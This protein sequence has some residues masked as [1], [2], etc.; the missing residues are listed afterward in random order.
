MKN[1]SC[2]CNS[3][4]LVRHISFCS[5]CEIS[6]CLVWWR[7]V[8]F[9]TYFK[10]CVCRIRRVVWKECRNSS[11]IHA[12]QTRTIYYKRAIPTVG[13][14]SLE[15][16]S[17]CV[18]QPL[19]TIY[20]GVS[21][22]FLVNYFPFYLFFLLPFKYL[23]LFSP[24]HREQMIQFL[25][26]YLKMPHNFCNFFLCSLSFLISLNSGALFWGLLCMSSALLRSCFGK[27]FWVGQ[28]EQSF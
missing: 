26:I 17:L 1:T 18:L 25:F 16:L 28:R 2:L 20:T 11:R 13:F 12:S 5:G 22:S 21:L 8:V 9:V 6:L 24:V 27:R 4:L 7:V 14:F 10:M 15:C 23:C 19:S 3:L